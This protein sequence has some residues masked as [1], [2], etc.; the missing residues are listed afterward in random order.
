L[1][2]WVAIELESA[3]NQIDFAPPAPL[4]GVEHR[5]AVGERAELYSLQLER[6][7]RVGASSSILWISRDDSTAGYD[8]EVKDRPYPR[9]IEVKGSSDSR[10]VTFF[11]SS[12]ELDVSRDVGS[13]YEVH[14]WGGVR[15]NLRASDDYA[16]LRA[17]GYPVVIKDP[18]SAL[19]GPD[20]SCEPTGYK[21]VR[22]G[23]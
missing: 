6:S 13:Q 8:I 23:D 9:C 18:S 22:L 12:N 16:R 15:L 17:E 10:G 11:F 7:A 21:V 1:P 5:L 19:F 20:W 4:T 3:W 14:F 2:D